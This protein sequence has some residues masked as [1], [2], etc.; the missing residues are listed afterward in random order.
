MGITIALNIT[1][2]HFVLF[3]HFVF[4]L[5]AYYRKNTMQGLSFGMNRVII[6]YLGTIRHEDNK[7]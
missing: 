5:I 6:I 7:A 4:F 1:I 2:D 3:H